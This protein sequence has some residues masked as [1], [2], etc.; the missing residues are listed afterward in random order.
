MLHHVP[1]PPPAGF[2]EQVQCRR[3]AVRRVIVGVEVLLLGVVAGKGIANAAIA[4]TNAPKI[5]KPTFWFVY[6]N[7]I[8]A[9]L[10]EWREPAVKASLVAKSDRTKL[11]TIIP[12]MNKVIT[13]SIS[14]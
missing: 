1:P 14:S 12:V 7:A 6:E 4:P 2:P 10:I 11:G 9:M 8:P 13:T 5:A 3:V